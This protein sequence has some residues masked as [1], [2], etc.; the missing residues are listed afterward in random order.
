MNKG[1]PRTLEE[2]I[3]NGLKE[4]YGDVIIDPNLVENIRAHV[5][6]FLAQKFCIVTT[7]EDPKLTKAALSLY[8]TITK[9][10]GS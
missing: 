4:K 6:D 5:K 7:G 3:L 10:S 8:K 9:G 1:T 2:A